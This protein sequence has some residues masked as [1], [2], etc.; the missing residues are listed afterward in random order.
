MSIPFTKSVTP[1]MSAVTVR[2]NGEIRVATQDHPRWARIEEIV[3]T[4]NNDHL[5]GELARLLDPALHVQEYFSRLSDRVSVSNGRL[6]LD[7]E[8]VSG[9]LAQHILDYIDDNEDAQPLVLFLENVVTNPN[10]HSR[11][12]LYD[13]L[14][15]HDFQIT[16]EGNFVAYK[17]VR[18]RSSWDLASGEDA[19]TYPYESI[20]RGTAIVDGKP[21]EGAIPNGVGAIVEMPRGEVAH[22]PAVGCHT[23]LHAGTYEYASNFSQGALLLVEINPRDVVSVPTDCNWQKIRTCRYK[24]IDVVTDKLEGTFYT[25]KLDVDE[26]EDVLV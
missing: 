12:Q 4:P 18:R 26:S 14:E 13:W 6:F 3:D 1:D 22:D 24:V 2:L 25:G 9:T 20:S 8:E 21:F 23:G 10:E 17:G 11:D 16:S 5:A 7:N 15:R 19:G